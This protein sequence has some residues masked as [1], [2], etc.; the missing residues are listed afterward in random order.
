M[1]GV[2]LL[3]RHTHVPMLSNL[4]A[5]FAMVLACIWVRCSGSLI[6]AFPLLAFAMLSSFVASLGGAAA[7]DSVRFLLILIG[8]IFALNCNL[9]GVRLPL[10][11]APL[12]LQAVIIIF[13]SGTLGASGNPE[14]AMLVRSLAIDNEWGD[15]YSHD[16]VYFRVQLIGN[17]L[18]PVL[19]MISALRFGWSKSYK[20]ATLVA[21]ASIIAAGNLT[22][23]ITCLAYTLVLLLKATKARPGLR[24]FVSTMA[25]VLG[26]SY[27]V[28]ALSEAIE[29][30]TGYSDSS[31]GV[32]LDQMN[33]V[34]DAFSE[35][36]ERALLGFGLGSRLPDG[37]ERNY[38]EGV[39]VELQ[40]LYLLYQ[41][42]LIGSILY[43]TTVYFTLRG[44]VSG[45]GRL[46]FWMYVLSGLSNP[47]IL[48]S[49]QII[50][51]LVIVGAFGKEGLFK[52]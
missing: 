41:L 8:T 7:E 4:L 42:G 10:V 21:A 40:A 25:L 13:I 17:A 9:R 39:Y 27:G 43:G 33:V 47:Y 11:M 34:A 14:L 45:D 16:G 32:R 28:A 44:R 48:D 35:H 52:R 36:P 29:S 20:I 30:K 51:S 46:I 23:I 49:N 50:T 18:L 1:L 5:P 38:S 12:V 22:Y 2:L 6:G 31:I 19:F 24:L 37:K 15:V 26:L 3:T